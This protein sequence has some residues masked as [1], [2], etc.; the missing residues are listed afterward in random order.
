MT[1]TVTISVE[2]FKK[3]EK[4]EA[5]VKAHNETSIK[6]LREYDKAH[7]DKSALR[8]KRYKDAHRESYNARRRELYRLKKAAAKGLTAPG[9]VTTGET[10]A[11]N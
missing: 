9:C 7:P 4:Y 10:A 6:E 5:R 3:L 8:S 1:D 11:P 2:R